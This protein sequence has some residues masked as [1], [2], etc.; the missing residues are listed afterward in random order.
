MKERI[1]DG[2]VEKIVRSDWAGVSWLGWSFGLKWW[3][4]KKLNS[5]KVKKKR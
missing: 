2:I 4:K 1:S 5:V 3:R